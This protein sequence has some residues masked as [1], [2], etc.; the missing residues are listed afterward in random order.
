L[1]GAGDPANGFELLSARLTCD[2]GTL[3]ALAIRTCFMCKTLPNSIRLSMNHIR[4][5]SK[6]AQPLVSGDVVAFCSVGHIEVALSARLCSRLSEV[7]N[8]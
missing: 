3:S 6:I 7:N 8:S 1:I 5:V 4:R 2:G